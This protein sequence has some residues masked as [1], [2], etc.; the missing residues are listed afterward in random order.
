MEH[1]ARAFK[2]KQ[3]FQFLLTTKLGFLLTFIVFA[4]AS[5]AQEAAYIDIGAGEISV[6]ASSPGVTFMNLRVMDPLG[7]IIFDQSSNGSPIQWVPNG[8]SVDGYYS[9]EVR[10]GFGQMKGVRDESHDESVRIR[11]WRKAGTVLVLGGAIV[12]PYEEEPND[13]EAGLLKDISDITKLAFSKF[14]DF[15]IA[16]AYADIVHLDDVIID[17][18]ECVGIDCY[19][20]ILFGSDTIRL[21]EN[22]LRIFFDDTSSTSSFPRNDWRI[23]INDSLDGGASYFAIQDATAG[24]VPF[25]IEAG[26]PAN[27]LYIEDYGRVGLGTSVPYV[28]LHIVDG[29]TPTVRLEQDGSSGWTPQTWD[30]AG[31]ES[32]F[33]IR[34]VT[35]GSKM[36]FRIQPN[37]PSSTLCL[38]SDGNVGVGTWS[39]T[40]AL[41][42]QRTDDA[43]ILV[44]NTTGTVAARVPL[45]LVNNGKTRFEI[46]NGVQSWT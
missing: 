40:S 12:P 1:V 19:S 25:R 27:S 22:N 13:G 26:A 39:A 10:V 3:S 14:M 7:E 38:K 6:T 30:L 28:E 34:D 11:P 32:N 43:Q 46:V 29:D 23:Q 36:P 15:L 33:F 8:M 41:H 44:E 2:L 4:S 9:Y 37:T 20:D 21:M 5:H 31:N 17:G 35:N 16:P 45:K 42:V 18:S 24:V